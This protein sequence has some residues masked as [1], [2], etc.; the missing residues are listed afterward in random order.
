EAGLGRATVPAA[1][2]EVRDAGETTAPADARTSRGEDSAD[3][4][5]LSNRGGTEN[6]N[7]ASAGTSVFGNVIMQATG[8]PA[9][10]AIVVAIPQGKTAVAG[11]DGSF[12]IVNLSGAQ[13]ALGARFG[14]YLSH[15]RQQDVELVAVEKNQRNGPFTV[16][17]L[18]GLTLSGTI[19]GE[20]TGQAVAGV[21]VSTTFPFIGELEVVTDAG[22]EYR[23]EGLPAMPMRVDVRAAGYA[24][25]RV[26]TSSRRARRTSAIS[27]WSPRAWPISGS[28]TRTGSLWTV[29]EWRSSSVIPFWAG[30]TK[31]GRT[32]RDDSCFTD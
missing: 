21:A 29:F 3:S 12:E 30:R 4:A 15:L 2:G 9:A 13:L 16:R 8:R 11:E 23:L 5:D 24:F 6:A 18:R 7:R 25:A 10:G 14:A 1:R 17:L 26:R 22:G 31:T 19:R 32:P 28:S 27:S 20:D